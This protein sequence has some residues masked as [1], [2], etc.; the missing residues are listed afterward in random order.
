MTK[1]NV[2]P[3]DTWL[4]DFRETAGLTPPPRTLSNAASRLVDL[5]DEFLYS[6]QGGWEIPPGF[7][8]DRFVPTGYG[9]GDLVAPIVQYLDDFGFTGDAR[10]LHE[11]ARRFYAHRD[12]QLKQMFPRPGDDKGWQ[13]FQERCVKPL[14]HLA[15][16]LQGVICD[17]RQLVIDAAAREAAVTNDTKEQAEA[18]SENGG[19]GGVTLS[20]TNAPRKRN[21]GGR[22]PEA[23]SK[24][25]KEVQRLW[26]GGK[27]R[28]KRHNEL[29]DHLDQDYGY[30]KKAL[31]R[32]S[33]KAR[34]KA[35]RSTK[36][37]K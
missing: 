24:G 17:I 31:D 36:A 13:E 5:M 9:K 18:N 28:F 34:R 10:R 27:G 12:W 14:G 4:A 15:G 25:D 23:L 1:R 3:A 7:P 11:A 21:T 32:I 30:T 29:D 19:D 35:A 22:K 6:L 37:T 20:A 26:A 2:P 16:C 33:G 8:R